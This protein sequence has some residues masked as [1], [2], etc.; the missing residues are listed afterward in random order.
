MNNYIPLIQTGITALVSL[1]VAYGTWHATEKQQ[2]NK[3]REEIM[4]QLEAHRKEASRDNSTLQEEVA[5]VKATVQNQVSIIELKIDDLSKRVE[6]HNNVI[7]RTYKLEQTAALHEEQIK[8]ANHRIE[9]LEK[10]DR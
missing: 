7:E 5:N 6:K 8:V 3:E 10:N 1:I 2:R 9:D 4:A